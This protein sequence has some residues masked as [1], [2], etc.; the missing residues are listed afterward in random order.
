MSQYFGNCPQ[1]R[2]SID[3]DGGASLRMDGEINRVTE[4]S[5][6]GERS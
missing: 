3:G 5:L 1:L 6:G 2:I 4:P